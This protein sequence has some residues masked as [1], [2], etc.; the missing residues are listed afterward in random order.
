M[1][2]TNMRV[3]WIWVFERGGEDVAQVSFEFPGATG[4]DA[5][6]FSVSVPMAALFSVT[7]FVGVLLRERLELSG[8]DDPRELYEFDQLGR[9]IG[10]LEH[11]HPR[12][13]Q[14]MLRAAKIHSANAVL[15]NRITSLM[16]QNPKGDGDAA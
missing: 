9:L 7:K 11:V 4:R 12:V 14:N 13:W 1:D 15:A 2:E 3:V 10:A 16:C 8:S 5:V 6:A